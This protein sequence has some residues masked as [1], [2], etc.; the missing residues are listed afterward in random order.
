MVGS[1]E[2]KEPP[3][4]QLEALINSGADSKHGRIVKTYTTDGRSYSVA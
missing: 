3:R 4:L 1:I 2:N